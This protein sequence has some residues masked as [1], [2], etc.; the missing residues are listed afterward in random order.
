MFPHPVR[1]QLAVLSLVLPVAGCCQAQAMLV[2]ASGRLMFGAAVRT[3]AAD[4]S[5]LVSFNAAQVGLVGDANSGQN[6][7]DA[8]LNFAR[9]DATT[10]AVHA[11][12]DVSVARGPWSALVRLK[13]WHDFALADQPRAWGNN[14][15]N[16]I[17]GRPLGDAGA[18]RLSRFSGV[19][20]GDAFVQYAAPGG[21]RAWMVRAGQQSLPWGEQAVFGG[22]LGA[23]NGADLPA[24]RRA[25]AAPQQLRV[26]APMLFVRAG[27]TRT[28]AVE[29]FY[30]SVFRPSALDMCGTFWTTTDYLAQG[31]DRA[32]AGPMALSDRERLAAGAFLKRIPS[33]SANDGPQYGGAI[34][35]KTPALELGLYAARYINRT[36]IPGVRKS[37]RTG[38]GFIPGDPDGLNL[39][40]FTEHPDDVKVYAVSAAYQLART[41]WS[42]ELAYR[43][44]QA[45]QL[46]PGDVLPAFLSTSAPSLIR[47]DATATAP[48]AYFRG[49]DRGR[50]V[51]LQLGWQRTLATAGAATVSTAV[52]IIGKHVMAL[53][54]PAV[55]RYGRPD[56]FG[57]GPIHGVCVPNSRE[58]ARQCSFDGYVSP[59]AYGYRLR[60][61]A[62]LRQLRPGLNLHAFAAFT[63]DV[64]GWAHDFLLS[65][66]R[67]SMNLS[68]RMDYRERYIAELSYLPI[69]D[70]RYSNLRDKDLLVLAAGVKF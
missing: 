35:W 65:E 30:G 22:G 7:D 13:A 23:I 15:N 49:Y 44:N 63:H 2:K 20:L 47:P 42:G 11:F 26:P 28:V 25:G 16:Y 59:S 31:C 45:L 67:K 36:P 17:G 43:P 61:D 38:P 68:L 50:T 39:A 29:A 52:D 6:T 57:T 33:P 4:P 53:P 55:R 10:R 48:G 18:A 70:G 54:D 41:R 46:P 14:P 56:Q 12:A 40:F 37:T 27:V 62:R 34:S 32:F 58:V 9:G 3:E 60:V 8:N 19:A 5:L 64:K 66:G 1:Q 24:L 51:Q 21:A 69:W